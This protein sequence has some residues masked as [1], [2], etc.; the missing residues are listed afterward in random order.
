A[1]AVGDDELLTM[2]LVTSYYDALG[3]PER[4]LAHVQEALA[5]ANRLDDA[6]LKAL[7][8]RRLAGVLRELDLAE[9]KRCCKEA[10]ALSAAAADQDGILL[11]LLNL[12]IVSL[13]DQDTTSARAHAERALELVAENPNPTFEAQLLATLAWAE[14]GDGHVAAARTRFIEA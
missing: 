5:L 1:R 6:Y 8:A 7:A 3:A 2:A 11:S 14:L 13:D 9:S 10:L 4:S 12:A